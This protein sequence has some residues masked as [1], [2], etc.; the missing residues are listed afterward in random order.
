[1]PCAKAC[2][3]VIAKAW[4]RYVFGFFNGARPKGFLP[5][6]NLFGKKTVM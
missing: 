6:S 4:P 1:M 2:G 5:L 3:G